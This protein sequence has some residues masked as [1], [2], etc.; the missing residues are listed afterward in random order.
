MGCCLF[1]FTWRATNLLLRA[2]S[3]AQLQLCGGGLVKQPI[4]RRGGGRAQPRRPSQNLLLAGVV[5]CARQ[6]SGRRVESACRSAFMGR[7]AAARGG[8]RERGTRRVA[9]H[10]KWAHWRP[11]LGSR[12]SP[13]HLGDD[14]LPSIH[15]DRGPCATFAPT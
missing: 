15:P 13:W 1:A 2:A 8:R 5:E 11:P 7:P 10:S 3:P 14:S 9:A 12:S 6:R 4:S